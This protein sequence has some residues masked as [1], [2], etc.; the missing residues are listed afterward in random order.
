M[1]RRLVLVNSAWL[2]ADKIVRLGVGLIVWVWL[3]RHFG[4]EGF[5]LW[6]YA[7]AF[8]ALF[9]AFATLGMDGVL[10]RELVRD[11]SRTGMLLGTAMGLRLLASAL[12]AFAS[13]G[14]LLWLRP[15][16]WLPLVLVALNAVV[17][18]FQSAQVIDLYFQA[19]MHARPA[20]LAVNMAFLVTTIGRLGLL[21]IE[22]P[23]AWFAVTLV[24]EAGLAASLLVVAYRSAERNNTP[25]QF[26]A[27]VAKALLLESWP[28]L[29]S[30]LAVMIYMR[31]DQVMLASMAGDEAVGQ[32]SAALRIAEVWYFI[33][34]ALMSAAFPAMMKKREEGPEAYERYVQR[35]Y[36][37][38]AWLGLTVAIITS[39]A[40]S[41]VV[42]LLYGKQFTPAAEILSIQ[43]WAGVTVTMSFVHSRWLLA[44]GLQ[45]YGLVYTLL[46]ACVNV[47][48]NLIL[49]PRFGP[50][51]AAW[52]TLV[53]QIGL[54]P[55]QLMFP[56]ARRN[57][58]LMVNAVT[59]PYRLVKQ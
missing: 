28:L 55:A 43:I 46:G 8:T 47:S 42:P 52:A 34:M 21:A 14:T 50:H 59:A 3:A 9:G 15:G 35:L 56:K 27:H 20:V 40:A 49:I 51:G 39:L 10:V 57:F 24:I 26:D 33:P 6:N 31:M 36:D 16:E 7:I 22:A 54:L 48:L 58:L 19:R 18:V 53:T 17:L 5:G 13:V 30:S 32:F 4:P 44:E 37:A 25:W 29:L 2:M 41:W 11:P 45:R 38:M 23:M 1:T 12:A